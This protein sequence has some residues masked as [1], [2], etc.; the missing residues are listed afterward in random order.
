MKNLILFVFLLQFITIGCEMYDTNNFPDTE[1][2]IN[3]TGGKVWYKIFG[4]E[5]A[6]TPLL[7]VHGGPGA[8]YDYLET[9]QALSDE[10]P[11]VFYDQMSCGKSDRQTDTTL[12][13]IDRFVEELEQVR[14]YLGLDK[15]HL[16]GQSWGAALSLEYYL[17]KNQS[18]IQSITLSGPLISTKMWVDDQRKYIE[19]LPDSI[20]KVIELAEKNGEFATEEYQNAVSVFYGKHLCRMA[21]WPECLLRS[22]NNLS[23]EL[24]LYMWGP[25]EFTCTGTLKDLDLSTELKNVD[26]PVL[27][28]CGEFDEASPASVSQFKNKTPNSE[29]V[30]FKDASHSHHLEKES[31]Y[32]QILRNFLNK[33]K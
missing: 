31:E 13:T 28:T 23:M 14:K 22:L 10:R 18:R 33:V 20:R 15:F 25:S 29:I 21:E 12:W 32:I 16:L 5:K 11:V 1:G 27:Y 26:I 8:S 24:Y 6:G 4:A 7:V 3:V 9:L 30:I 17:K 2:F 19:Q